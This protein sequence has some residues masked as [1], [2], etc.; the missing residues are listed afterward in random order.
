LRNTTSESAGFAKLTRDSFELGG[1]EFEIRQRG[2]AAS[3]VLA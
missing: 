2:N 3:W 1:V